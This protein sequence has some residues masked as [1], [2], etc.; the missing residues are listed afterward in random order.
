MLKY[1]TNLMSDHQKGA[2]LTRKK[3]E[4]KRKAVRYLFVLK[5]VF[6]FVFAMKKIKKRVPKYQESEVK[7]RECFDNLNRTLEL[8]GVRRFTSNVKMLFIKKQDFEDLPDD[9]LNEVVKQI[10]ITSP[11]FEFTLKFDNNK[12][13]VQDLKGKSLKIFNPCKF[14]KIEKTLMNGFKC[15]QLIYKE[16]ER[17]LIFTQKVEKQE[18]I[19]T[20][21]S[22]IIQSFKNLAFNTNKL[23]YKGSNMRTDRR[24]KAN[25]IIQKG[26]V[27]DAF[28]TKEAHPGRSVRP[29]LF[30][31]L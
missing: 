5:T 29:N 4:T 11:L 17:V 2:S 31:L 9:K 20:Q 23:V 30:S 24:A 16:Y 6:Q 10:V 15:I 19:F 1:F 27:Q 14:I 25:K 22:T 28:R 3:Q 7:N 18:K 21:L 26:V 8:A 13:I 12:L